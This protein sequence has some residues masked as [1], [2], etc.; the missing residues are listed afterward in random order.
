MKWSL[1]LLKIKT[2]IDSKRVWQ[3]SSLPD[4]PVQETETFNPLDARKLMIVKESYEKEYIALVSYT[5]FLNI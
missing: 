5:K 2:N 4:I 1:I 3:C